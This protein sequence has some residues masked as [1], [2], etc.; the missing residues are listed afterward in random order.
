MQEIILK[1]SKTKL[2][3]NCI[4]C[5]DEKTHKNIYESLADII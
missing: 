1:N 2:D 3:N 5:K 4:P